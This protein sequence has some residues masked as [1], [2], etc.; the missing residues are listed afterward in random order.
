MGTSVLHIKT[1]VECKVFLFDEEKGIAT[2]S[3]YFNLEVRKGEQDLLFISVLDQDIQCSISYQVEESD[4]DY[5]LTLEE[6]QF[7]ARRNSLFELL[8]T[9]VTDEEVTE[10]T[11]D[12]S[13]VIYSRD[14]S[15]LLQCKNKDIASYEVKE[16][17]IVI[18]ESAFRKCEN[19]VNITL[20][21]GLTH[22]GD[23]VFYECRKLS[24]ISLPSSL[25]HIGRGAFLNCESLTSLI[26]PSSITYI[27]DSAFSG[28]S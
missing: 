25:T 2:P 15:Q 26:F 11:E 5:H 6:S 16:G 20:P 10:G 19:L 28:V 3:K 12:N 22:M 27:G 4:C 9:E 1:E 21:I 23:C 18:R 17:C 14:G 8:S 13:G 24:N 7:M